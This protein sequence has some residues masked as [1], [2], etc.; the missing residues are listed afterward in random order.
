MRSEDPLPD[1]RNYDAYAEVQDTGSP[2]K[3]RAREGKGTDIQASA[4]KLV[5]ALH[6]D[7]LSSNN[8]LLDLSTL[9]NVPPS[10]RDA[11][12]QE[13][14]CDGFIPQKQTESALQ[15]RVHAC[16]WV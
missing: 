7:E 1:S 6:G 16:D 13:Q 2:I 9:M 10:Q 15:A 4:P 14:L 11:D 8:K 5:S 12:I 3:L